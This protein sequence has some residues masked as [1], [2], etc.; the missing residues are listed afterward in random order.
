MPQGTHARR[1]SALITA[2]AALALTLA[3]GSAGAMAAP[4]GQGPDGNGPP[5]H[6]P[7]PEFTA[8]SDDDSKESGQRD[9]DRSGTAGGGASGQKDDR[10]RSHAEDQGP[11]AH[12]SGNATGNKHLSAAAEEPDSPTPTEPSPTPAP[13]GE[14]GEAGGQTAGSQGAAGTADATFE[15]EPPGGS[16]APASSPPASSPPADGV[17]SGEAAAGPTAAAPAPGGEESGDDALLAQNEG[18]PAD[19]RFFERVRDRAVDTV[20]SPGRDFG[21]PI[22][23]L[24]ILGTYLAFQRRLDRGVL[25]MSGLSS[26]PDGDFHVRYEL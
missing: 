11:P 23:L 12:A 19:V 5:G 6:D 15:P 4:Q 9:G 21:V 16:S 3:L 7:D 24:A 17:P 14:A 26:T 8:Q 1:A 20:L 2:G 25:P 18:P 10:P 13:A 22:L